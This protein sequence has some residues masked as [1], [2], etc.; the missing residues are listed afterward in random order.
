MRKNADYYRKNADY[1]EYVGKS[2][3]Y[4]MIFLMRIIK[5]ILMKDALTKGGI[6]HEN[7]KESMELFTDFF[8]DRSSPAVLKEDPAFDLQST[9]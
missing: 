1:A 2:A 6:S 5:K 8:Q 3:I 7:G 4:G 9:R